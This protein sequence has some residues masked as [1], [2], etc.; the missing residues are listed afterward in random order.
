MPEIEQYANQLEWVENNLVDRD[1]TKI[2][3]NNVLIDLDRRLD[4][5]SFVQVPEESQ[6]QIHSEQTIDQPGPSK[7]RGPSEQLEASKHLEGTKWLEEY[8]QPEILE[9]LAPPEKI[10]SNP[11]I[12]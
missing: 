12:L 10:M 4:E 7:Q 5:D 8:E 11:P 6:S 3:V 1:S 9:E 2:D